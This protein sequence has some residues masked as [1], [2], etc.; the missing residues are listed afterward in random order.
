M[1]TKRTFARPVADMINHNKQHAQH[2]TGYR[3]CALFLGALFLLLT[4]GCV[5]RIHVHP[6]PS[7]SAPIAISKSLRVVVTVL[8]LEGADHR[9]GITLLEWSPSDLRQAIVQYARQRRTFAS[10][11]DER[12]D[13]TLE[14]RAKLALTSRQW[15]YHY[16][17]RLRAE[18]R[19]EDRMLKAYS[20]E[21]SAE[22]SFARWVTASDRIPIESAL[23]QAL[24]IL[25]TQIETDQILYE[26]AR[27]GS[28]P[29]PP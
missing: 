13:L 21:G 12:P 11:V 8:A 7:A 28:P 15:R 18:M 29:S 4:A 3:Y 24:D 5:H 9:P 20:A 2:P 22:G 6:L 10:L 25:F 19:K 17:I 1:P 14:I 16:Q 27:A 26:E 23:Q